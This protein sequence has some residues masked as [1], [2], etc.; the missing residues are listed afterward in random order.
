LVPYD[1]SWPSEAARLVE[2]INMALGD[3]PGE[4]GPGA[5]FTVEH[6]GSTSVPGLSAKDV[7]DI[8]IGVP[9]LADADATRFV[10]ALERQGFPRVDGNTDD[11][12]LPW[13]DDRS[14]WRKRFH[15]SADPARSTHVH[16]RQ[17]DGPG[18]RYA[19]LFRDW[20]RAHS[21]EREAY[22]TL[23][24]RLAQ[25]AGTT[26]EYVEAK[27]PWIVDAL[28]RADVWAQRTGWVGQ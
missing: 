4:A 3:L 9:T 19:L 25:S 17:I 18:W 16:V 27:S 11:D 2:R 7:N 21:D 8:Q 24:R 1:D 10:K 28:G 12:P 23:K 20:L 14:V 15:C 6:I 26:P 13:V 5:G 22:A